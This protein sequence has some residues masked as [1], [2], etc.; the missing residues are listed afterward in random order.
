MLI[1]IVMKKKTFKSFYKT[2]KNKRDFATKVECSL[3][4]L[5]MLGNGKRRAS[6]EMAKRIEKHSGGVVS[7][8]RMLGL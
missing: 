8:A 1:I 5:W 2:I 6:P 3:P 7:A 4:Y